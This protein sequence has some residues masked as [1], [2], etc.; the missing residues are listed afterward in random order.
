MNFS[1]LICPHT[2][3]VFNFIHDEFIPID[4]RM[5]DG[6]IGKRSR[7]M[8]N[9]IHAH[10]IYISYAVGKFQPLNSSTGGDMDQYRLGCVWPSVRRQFSQAF[11]GQMSH[12][13]FD[14]CKGERAEG[15][16]QRLLEF[17]I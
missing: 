15:K 14:I 6:C 16:R 4:N 13:F 8:L 10:P 5:D 7:F 3:K 9:L 2:E 17:K 11:Q 1:R 12:F